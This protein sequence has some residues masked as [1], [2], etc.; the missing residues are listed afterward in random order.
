M[1]QNIKRILLAILTC[2][3][4]IGSLWIC[5]IYIRHQLHR[6]GLPILGYHSVVP[7][8]EKNALYPNDPYVLSASDFEKQ[9]QY[10]YVN[11]YHTLTLDQVYEYYMG[12][13]TLH[14]PSIVLTFDD[15]YL[16]F[17]TIVKPILEKYNFHASA[18]VIGKK[19][20]QKNTKYLHKKDLIPDKTVSYY[21]HSYDLHH[22]SSVPYHK[23]LEIASMQEIENDI[24]KSSQIVDTSYY[25]YPYGISTKIAKKALKN[26]QIKLAFGFNENRHMTR[27]DDQY[28]LPRYLI[29]GN[30]PMW[31]F[32]WIVEQG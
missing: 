22:F 17:N 27:Q 24:T 20:H 13:S 7:N 4:I 12:T 11:Q 32:K 26:K 25:A 15:G 30:M 5:Q 3:I 8:P 31:Y 29:F 23:M 19:V 10:L 18:F 16:N 14:T 1:L 9:M 21:S 2:Y 28:A 6:K